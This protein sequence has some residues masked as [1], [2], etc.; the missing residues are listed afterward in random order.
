MILMIKTE[1]TV[2]S[3]WVT[4]PT[5]SHL[6]AIWAHLGPVGGTW[7]KFC[8]F[9]VTLRQYKYEFICFRTAFCFVNISAP[10]Y[11]TEI[12]LYS[13]FA[14]GSH[15]S[16]E[17]TIWKSNAWLPRYL[18]NKHWTIFFETPCSNWFLK[19]FGKDPYNHTG[20]PGINLRPKPLH[21]VTHAWIF[22]SYA[23]LH[24]Q[25]FTIQYYLMSLSLQF[26]KDLS[27]CCVDIYKIILMFCNH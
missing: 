21:F 24:A 3:V 13:K 23:P 19:S 7:H 9:K 1:I 22:A 15:F 2:Q 12:V 5:R 11:R 17:K 16:G 10:E 20:M 25:I 18:Q 8:G 4:R 14:Y 26:H 6:G 27:F